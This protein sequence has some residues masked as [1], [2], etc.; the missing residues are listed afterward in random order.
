MVTPIRKVF[1]S[2]DSVYFEHETFRAA[3]ELASDYDEEEPTVETQVF[4]K[5]KH[6]EV[7]TI[8][9][10]CH[11]VEQN[12]F[13]AGI[14]EYDI[15]LPKDVVNAFQYAFRKLGTYLEQHGPYVAE[16]NAEFHYITHITQEM[17]DSIEQ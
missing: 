16:T 13:D 14:E 2:P 5:L 7:I 15:N 6:E 17:I 12:I 10:I 1:H 4:R 11:I 8:D 3:M 9:D